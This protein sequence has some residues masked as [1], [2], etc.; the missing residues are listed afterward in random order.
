MAENRTFDR[1]VSGLSDEEKQDFLNRLQAQ[2][3]TLREP[4][5]TM[6]EADLLPSVKTTVEARYKT[7]S[8]YLTIWF[9]IVSF[10]TGKT[11]VKLFENREFLVAGRK[12]AEMYPGIYDSQTNSLLDGFRMYFSEL[13][14]AARFFYTTLDASV[15]KDRGAFFAFLGG[16]E[17][18][19]VN[20]KLISLSN[21]PEFIKKNPGVSER[22]LLQLA[23]DQAGELLDHLDDI[24][25]KTMYN[26]AR[27]V[28]CLSELSSILYDRILAS[29]RI[30][31]AS[32]VSGC[33]LPPLKGQISKLNDIMFSMKTPPSPA[34]A[35]AL[36]LF[37]ASTRG[38]S[39]D[40]S[41][42][43][44]DAET[45]KNIARAEKA[46]SVIRTFNRSVPLKELARFAQRDMSL[47][48][49][50]LTGGEEWYSIYKNYWIKKVR[51]SFR[52]Y[53]NNKRKKDLLASLKKFFDNHEIEELPNINQ[54]IQGATPEEDIM[55]VLPFELG[56]VMQIAYL[57]TFAKRVF[58]PQMNTLLRT[59]L[60]NGDFAET[61]N[62]T[63]YAEAYAILV[64]L[65]SSI[66]A[67]CE[68]LGGNSEWGMRIS[69]LATEA[70]SAQIRV[71]KKA[72][73][74][75]EVNGEASKIIESAKAALVSAHNIL[76]GI[77]G[78]SAQS[79]IMSDKLADGRNPAQIYRHLNNI[80]AIAGKGT[81]FYDGINQCIDL[82]EEALTLLAEVRQEESAPEDSDDSAE[83]DE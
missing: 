83:D 10:F 55:P 73:L 41:I 2:A 61:D 8:W 14:E 56:G 71:R 76:C 79:F 51:S 21:P 54:K 81:Q 15:R 59:I 47:E 4:L 25:R 6:Q 37:T 53:F 20:A 44:I 68:R 74:S 17:M 26:D 28:K 49:T 33:P 82:S 23:R 64:G 42:T 18:A 40:G 62:K 19:D 16:L 46:L 65:D 58:L 57:L 39:E 63:E 45:A 35:A 48:P 77:S 13:K 78:R 50:E 30:D 72:S 75:E 36:F 34:L 7:T 52:D 38:N 9:A 67:F 29:Y 24:N 5:R 12:L 60:I 1:L 11:P 70:D 32:G 80:A 3:P 43:D 31:N 27:S 66:K 69:Q 22:A